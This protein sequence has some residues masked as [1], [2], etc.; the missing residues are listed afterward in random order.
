MWKKSM[1]NPS[2]GTLL[3]WWQCCGAWFVWHNCHLHDNGASHGP[4]YKNSENATYW[5]NMNEMRKHSLMW[6]CKHTDRLGENIKEGFHLP[7]ISTA[8]IWRNNT[9]GSEVSFSSLQEGMASRSCEGKKD[10]R[11]C[12]WLTTLDGSSGEETSFLPSKELNWHKNDAG[13][14]IDTMLLLFP[15]RSYLVSCSSFFGEW[16]DC[17]IATLNGLLC[18]MLLKTTSLHWDY[19]FIC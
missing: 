15:E 12:Q 4:N 9:V 19:G 13:I 11:V 16:N 5:K 7:N 8:F 18:L 10:N 6:R 14:W 1:R 3:H 2:L 17:N